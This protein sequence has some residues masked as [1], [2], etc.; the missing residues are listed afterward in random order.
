MNCV[1]YR[2]QT[3]AVSTV[4]PGPPR[5]EVCRL[6]ES[7]LTAGPLRA[8]EDVHA[9]TLVGLLLPKTTHGLSLILFIYLFI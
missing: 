1:L 7:L 6:E 3:L 8:L 4:S 5:A 9:A 2:V